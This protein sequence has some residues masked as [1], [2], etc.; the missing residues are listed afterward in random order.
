MISRV[1]RTILDQ[2]QLSQGKGVVVSIGK[3][4]GEQKNILSQIGDF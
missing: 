4:Y 1:H 3:G 2:E